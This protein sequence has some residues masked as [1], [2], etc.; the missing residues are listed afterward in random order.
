VELARTLDASIASG[1]VAI[2]VDD[3]QGGTTTIEAPAAEFEAAERG[4]AVGRRFFP[5]HR[6]HRYE[7][8]LPPKEVAE[9]R[10][11]AAR[12]RLVVQ[13]GAGAS[14]EHLVPADGFETAAFAVT[15]L[16][17]DVA[18]TENG[19]ISVRRVGFPWHRVLEYERILADSPDGAF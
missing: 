2:V 13:D 10:R 7:W 12:V 8:D 5:W 11:V 1:V 19:T 3:G 14:R 4:I 9:D 6:I 17:E 18:D 16:V 15:V